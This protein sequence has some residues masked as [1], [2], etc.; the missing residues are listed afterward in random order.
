MNVIE[1]SNYDSGVFE[2]LVELRNRI[3]QDIET[4]FPERLSD[5][6]NLFFDDKWL[7]ENYSWRFIIVK[8]ENRILV[9][10]QPGFQ[11]LKYCR[12]KKTGQR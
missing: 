12:Q 2:E 4:S 6:K 8:R 7:S 1:I 11:K 5:L 10:N 9:W 3:H